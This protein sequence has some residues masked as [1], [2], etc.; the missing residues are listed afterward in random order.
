VVL[1]SSILFGLA[2]TYQGRSG[3]A[4]TTLMGLVFGVAR[5]MMQSLGPV[6]VWHAVVDLAAGIAGPR[7]L[8][9]RVV[10]E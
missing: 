1:I 10:K 2:H 4:G 3:V 7:F 6:M 5:V 8:L 9:Q